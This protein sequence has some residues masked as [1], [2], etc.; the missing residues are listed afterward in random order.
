MRRIT[1]RLPLTA[2][3]SL[4]AIFIFLLLLLS[5]SLANDLSD[6]QA[7]QPTLVVFLT[8]GDRVS[9]RVIFISQEHI[10]LENKYAGR[11]RI[12]LAEM[13]GWQTSDAS[14]RAR[15]SAFLPLKD[16]DT[17]AQEAS[18]AKAKEAIAAKDKAVV[19]NAQ[20]ALVKAGP[21]PAKPEAWKRQVNFAYT[22]TRGNVRSSDMN[23]AFNVSRKRGARKIALT[24]YGRYGV[25]NG[26]ESANLFSSTFRYE[27]TA[28]RLPVF[29]ETQFEID[30]LKKLDYRL[31]SNLG[32]SYPVIKGDQ[33]QL[34]FD[35]GT[36]VT[37]EDYATGLQK[38]NATSL[39]RLKASQKLTGK[40]L[41]H[42]QATFFSDLTDPGAY[43]IQAEASVTTPIT[44]NLALR[45]AGINRYDARPQGFAKPNDFTLLT[46]FTFD[47]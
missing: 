31:S 11:L 17:L 39:L 13:K 22:M 41:L 32:V 37:K 43:R 34:A 5:G 40:T 15:L 46:G 6:P 2:Y 36:G 44:K 3:V 14:L 29:A 18:Q 47:F 25:K 12:K 4:P 38:L 33:Q 19:V 35:F 1:Y 24:S 23:V 7:G 27:R 21:K 42:Q 30:K 9:G 10:E 26:K 16:N 20:T 8:N 28:F 45:L